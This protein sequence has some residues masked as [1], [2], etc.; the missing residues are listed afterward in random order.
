MALLRPS[1]QGLSSN[2]CIVPPEYMPSTNAEGIGGS[3]LT[4]NQVFQYFHLSLLSLPVPLSFSPFPLL[5][6]SLALL[7][8]KQQ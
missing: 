5:S 3:A 7:P 2:C 8:S 4:Q 1:G 6:L